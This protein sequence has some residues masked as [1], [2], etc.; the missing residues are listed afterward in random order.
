MGLGEDGRVAKSQ[1]AA[2]QLEWADLQARLPSTACSWECGH[3]NSRRRGVGLAVDAH[4]S[5]CCDVYPQRLS[6]LSGAQVNHRDEWLACLRA[7]FEGLDRD[8]DG[9]ISTSEIMAALSKKLPEEEA[10]GE[11]GLCLGPGW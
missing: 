11:S 6:P 9:I 4:Q 3:G 8:G 10:S 7:T 2:S 5:I 1:F